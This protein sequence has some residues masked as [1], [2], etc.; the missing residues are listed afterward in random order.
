[1]AWRTGARRSL[2]A[3]SLTANVAAPQ[4]PCCT[5]TNTYEENLEMNP[6]DRDVPLQP[7]STNSLDSYVPAPQKPCCAV[8]IHMKKFGNEPQPDC[9]TLT[10]GAVKI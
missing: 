1:M 4:Q 10:H 2:K 5:V 3:L 9:Q 6:I 8:H 7:N